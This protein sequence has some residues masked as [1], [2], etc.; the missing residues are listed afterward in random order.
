MSSGFDRSCDLGRRSEEMPVT[1]AIGRFVFELV[2]DRVRY[3]VR[4]ENWMVWVPPGPF[5]YG[6][7]SDENMA[8]KMLPR[9]W[10]DKYPVTNEQFCQFL[11]RKRAEP[12]ELWL[13][14]NRSKV[15]STGSGGR[16]RWEVEPGFEHHRVTGVTWHGASATRSGREAL[17]HRGGMGEGGAWNRWSR[18]PVGH[19]FRPVAMQPVGVRQTGDVGGGYVRPV[20]L[21]VLWRLRHGRE[22]LRVDGQPVGRAAFRDARRE[23]GLRS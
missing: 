13:D 21:V 8:V 4:E 11:N 5:L 1:D 14:E 12:G 7:D 15:Q 20:R 16:L 22:C 3:E 2:A 17:A 18:V 19:G 9:Y 23:L 10:I 6:S